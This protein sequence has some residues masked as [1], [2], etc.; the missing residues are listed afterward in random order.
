[1]I[2]IYLGT[3]TINER[4]LLRIPDLVKEKL[5]VKRKETVNFF[6]VNGQVIIEKNVPPEKPNLNGKPRTK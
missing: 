5:N 6:Y 2:L 1:M 4:D 3:S